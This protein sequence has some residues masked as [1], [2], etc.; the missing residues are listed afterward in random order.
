MIPIEP[1][2]APLVA[3]IVALPAELPLTTPA[4]DTGAIETAS[5][6]QVT[7]AP[8]IGLP[9]ASRTVA[10]SGSVA[11]TSRLVVDALTTTLAGAGLGGDEPTMLEYSSRFAV[12]PGT[13]VNTLAVAPPTIADATCDGLADR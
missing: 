1:F 4:E 12:P 3:V 9:L 7:D 2:A 11:P 10:V 13:A 5:L 6:D 8:V